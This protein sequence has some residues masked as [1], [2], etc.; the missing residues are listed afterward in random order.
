MDTFMYLSMMTSIVL[1]LGV[2]R[3]FVGIGTIVEYRN[4]VRLYWVQ[5]LWAL[6]LL[7]FMVLEWWILFR[8]RDYQ[9]WNYFLFL[10]L[11]MSPSISFLL[12]VILFPSNTEKTDFKQIFYGNRRW[13]FSMAALLMPLD[14]ADTLLKGYAHFQAQGVIYPVSLSTVFAL[15]V[16]GA[17]WKNETY[18]KCFAII[19]L[20]YVVGFILINLNVLT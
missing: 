19:F 6:N 2:T 10:F 15:T 8:W 3:L 5:L 11:L 14:A 17:I 9:D 1:G 16:L 20:L 4:K 12:S 18:H 7:L 13:F